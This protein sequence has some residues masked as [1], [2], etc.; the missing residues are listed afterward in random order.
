MQ[1]TMQLTTLDFHKKWRHIPECWAYSPTGEAQ[2]YECS[3]RYRDAKIDIIFLY[4]WG[5]F[6][7][8]RSTLISAWISN[9]IPG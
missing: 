1:C 3:Q 4:I 5:F 7:W 2:R 6:Y 9:H 8:Y